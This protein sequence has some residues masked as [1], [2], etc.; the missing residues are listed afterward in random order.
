MAILM[1]VFGQ[2]SCNS[3]GHFSL[4]IYESIGYGTSMWFIHNLVSSVTS[5]IGALAVPSLTI[6]HV[7]GFSSSVSLSVLLWQPS[8]V[9]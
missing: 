8:I 3:L 9:V 2:F 1:G 6:C 4:N 5:Y 7:A